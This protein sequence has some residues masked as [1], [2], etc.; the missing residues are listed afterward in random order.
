MIETMPKY[1]HKE[2]LYSLRL[3]LDICGFQC[4][5]NQILVCQQISIQKL[6]LVPDYDITVKMQG[7]SPV[8]EKIIPSSLC[9]QI[10][11]RFK[12]NIVILCPI[13]YLPWHSLDKTL[14]EMVVRDS[15]L[16]LRVYNIGI[17]MT[18]Q[19]HLVLLHRELLLSSPYKKKLS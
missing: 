14:S 15:D 7:C 1:E 2:R 8:W 5:L 4:S 12:K 13:M 16:N 17:T 9:P 6:K 19:H 3:H 11:Y 18:Q 10:G